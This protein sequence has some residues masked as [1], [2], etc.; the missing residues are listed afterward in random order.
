M[1]TQWI[2][3]PRKDGRRKVPTL[4]PQLVDW[5]ETMLCHG[6]GDL[7]GQPL[8]LD[9]EFRQ[10]ISDCY[11][12]H[13]GSGLRYVRRAFLS[14]PKGRA[15][16]E[17]AAIIAAAEGCGPVRFDHWAKAG[18][19]SWWGY[20][21][22]RGEPVGRPVTS[23]EI[24]CAATEESQAGNTYDNLL[25]MLPHA[26]GLFP[27]RFVGLDVG[28]TRVNLPGRGSIEPINA[29][30]SSKDGGKST[31]V[32]F[33]ETHLYNSPRLR[34][35][36]K[37][38]GRNLGKRKLAE[39]WRLE[40]STMYR[41][42]EDSVA[43]ATHRFA[44]SILA[45]ER[46]DYGLLFD[47]REGTDSFDWDND[48]ELRE[49]LIEAFGDAA[50]WQDFDRKIADIREPDSD[51]SESRRYW[52]NQVKSPSDQCVDPEQLRAAFDADLRLEDGDAIAVGFD[53]ARR[54]DATALM[55]CRM[56]DGAVFTFDVW[57]P[58]PHLEGQPHEIDP[59]D[60]D[61]SVDALMKR[62]DVVRFYGDPPYWQDKLDQWSGTYS[63]VVYEWWT[64]RPKAMH[65]AWERFQ[66]ALA[67]GELRHDGDERFVRHCLNATKNVSRLG[68]VRPS[69]RSRDSGRKIDAYMAAI[70]AVEA[71][72]DA[73]ADGWQPKKRKKTY[74]YS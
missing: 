21:Y 19:E 49:A 41:P 4:G 5:A 55:I 44:E 34:A 48:E 17:L 69:K 28:L 43:E 46:I 58:P 66:D 54:H 60:V 56:T 50:V 11:R 51:E 7:V 47:H 53:G 59:Q 74:S 23:P 33:D 20:E 63:K 40:T 3:P 64:N 14:R 1:P 52:L 72:A 68:Y 18:E 36:H 39:P 2:G 71:R 16:S 57:E 10:F 73:V 67:N 65:Y 22:R 25:V 27:Q 15:K 37:T 31:W 26:A 61:D 8:E 24:L 29:E 6:P 70:L 32:C 62:F 13:I 38:I 9:F 30:A 45:G 42:G 12:V 35:L